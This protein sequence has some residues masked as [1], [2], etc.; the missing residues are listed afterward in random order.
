MGAISHNAEMTPTTSGPPNRRA[1][2]NRVFGINRVAPSRMSALNARKLNAGAATARTF[3]FNLPNNFV[4][5]NKIDAM[6]FEI[7]RIVVNKAHFPNG[8]IT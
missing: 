7:D 6:A 8:V 5:T 4:L 2:R 3:K 1:N